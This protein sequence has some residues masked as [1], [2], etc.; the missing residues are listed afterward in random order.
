MGQDFTARKADE[1]FVFYLD[2]SRMLKQIDFYLLTVK[3]KRK[4]DAM[5]KI[6]SNYINN[7]IGYSTSNTILVYYM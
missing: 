6:K 1:T 4:K 7:F 3:E 2:V 5:K